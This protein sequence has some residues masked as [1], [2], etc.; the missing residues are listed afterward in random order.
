MIVKQDTAVI[1]I[2][3]TWYR[4]T[5]FTAGVCLW[6]R[7]V[8]PGR[9]SCQDEGMTQLHRYILQTKVNKENLNEKKGWKR[10]E[11]ILD[12]QRTFFLAYFYYL[13]EGNGPH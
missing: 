2:P 13:F 4:V 8:P 12:S 6:P 3:R 11:N 9:S 5:I 1:I 10:E 7:S